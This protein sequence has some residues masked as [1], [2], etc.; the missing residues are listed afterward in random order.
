M[1]ETPLNI[2]LMEAGRMIGIYKITIDNKNYIGQSTDILERWRH[3][4][5]NYLD[6]NNTL[7]LYQDMRKYGIENT[8][9]SI[10]ELCEKE[11]LNEKEEYYN[12]LYQA[13]ENG[14]NQ[15]RSYNTNSLTTEEVKK[16]IYSIINEEEKT[17][18]QIADENHTT[19]YVVKSISRGDTQ[20]QTDLIYPLRGN[21]WSFYCEKCGEKISSGH[22]YCKS[23][24]SQMRGEKQRNGV[25]K[26]TKEELQ[27][28]VY[29]NTFAD[30]GK[31]FNVDRSTISK[32]LKAYGL[33]YNKKDIKNFSK[34]EW[35][36][37]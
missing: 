23:C 37:L 15:S 13:Y 28:L 4:I 20:K 32:W 21:N 27:Q 16:I 14:Y 24:A 5:N 34:E 17:L 12:R 7:P 18:Q 3:H 22:K 33:P 19:L 10:L 31:Q 8:N 11:Q 9:F 30:L 6:T 29:N 25:K 35:L 2:F 36:A 1:E 26:P